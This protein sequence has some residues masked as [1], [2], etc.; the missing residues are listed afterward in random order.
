MATG[1]NASAGGDGNTAQPAVGNAYEESQGG[2][3]LLRMLW[4]ARYRIGLAM[5]VAA[6]AYLGVA[7]MRW[8]SQSNHTAVSQEITFAFDGARSGRYPD[9]SIFSPQDLLADPVLAL[10]HERLA[11]GERVT[12][13]QLSSALSIADA[14]GIEYAM[15]RAAYTEKLA[16][17]KLSP[18]ERDQIEE[19]YRRAMDRLAGSVFAINLNADG[20][21]LSPELAKQVVQSI[22]GSWAAYAQKVRGLA[23]YDIPIPSIVPADAPGTQLYHLALLTEELG[24]LERALIRLQELPGAA[25]L[26]NTT[27]RGPW[28][29]SR[30]ITALRRTGFEPLAD[31]VYARAGREG[32]LQLQSN[33]EASQRLADAAKSRADA[34]KVNFEFYV[35]SG[36][37]ETSAVTGGTSDARN[38]PLSPQAPMMVNLPDSL[39]SRM[40]ELGTRSEDLEY[41]QK[42]NDELAKA[43]KA[44]VEADCDLADAQ[45]RLDKAK[46]AQANPDLLREDSFL[47]RMNDVKRLMGEIAAETRQLLQELSRRNLNS[48][49]VFFR[50]QGP[51]IISTE[52]SFSI[53]SA[54][55]GFMGVQCFAVLAGLLWNAVSPARTRPTTADREGALEIGVPASLPLRRMGSA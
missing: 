3:D 15:V 19:N 1:T 30:Q 21:D 37:P 47:P 41:R 40:I 35:L 53:R 54:A 29:L 2:L 25:N 36:R 50:L 33:I 9:G 45:F 55:I 26:R 23:V 46:A 16:S 27:E 28:E 20:L 5:I 24:A 22:P 49:T 34:A 7:V 8:S 42:L 51:A 38:A 48:S 52:G 18:P 39:F 31:A 17:T 12:T 32:L 14:A 44:R 10:V 43:T 11:L 13:G 4:R 6:L